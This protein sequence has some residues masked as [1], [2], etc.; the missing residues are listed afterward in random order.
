MRRA[1]S[2]GRIRTVAASLVAAAA[3][4]AALAGSAPAAETN[5]YVV[6]KLVSDGFA[7]A[8]HVDSNLVNAWGAS[9]SP[10]TGSTRPTSTTAG[11]TSS[12]AASAG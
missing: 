2:R 1:R 8:D 7:P 10:A 5:A 12:T 9:P 11:S 3:A 4:V 6:H